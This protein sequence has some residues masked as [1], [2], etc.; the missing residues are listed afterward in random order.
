MGRIGEGYERRQSLLDSFDRRLQRNI[1]ENAGK[2]R[3]ASEKTYAEL[4][5]KSGDDDLTR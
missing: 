3:G 1:A 2:K 5:D 4:A